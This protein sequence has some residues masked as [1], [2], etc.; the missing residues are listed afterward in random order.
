MLY[1]S[2]P[3]CSSPLK[4]SLD[5]IGDTVTCPA[6]GQSFVVSDP[7][8]KPPKVVLEPLT[9]D[10]DEDD[11]ESASEIETELI[12]ARNPGNFF[13]RPLPW[14]G[15][16]L[17]FFLTFAVYLLVASCFQPEDPRRRPHPTSIPAS[18]PKEPLDA[19]NAGP[20]N[21]AK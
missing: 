21:Q 10:D 6:C 20:A 9:D 8:A 14:W 17:G 5:S 11:S 4:V 19:A 7:E 3:D 2:C 12:P 1:I 15:Y 13:T 16:V 18:S